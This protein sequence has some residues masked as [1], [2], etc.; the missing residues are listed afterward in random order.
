MSGKHPALHVPGQMVAGVA[1]GAAGQRKPRYRNA[2]ATAPIAPKAQTVR[3]AMFLR[4][5]RLPAS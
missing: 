2:T 3:A 5:S 4:P 1:E